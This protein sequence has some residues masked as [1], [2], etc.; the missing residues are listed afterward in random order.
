M[1]GISIF[2]LLLLFNVSTAVAYI[3]WVRP[4]SS[5]GA[6]DEVNALAI[7][8]EGNCY[9]TGNANGPYPAESD[10]RTIKYD[11]DGNVL[12]TAS[13]DGIAQEADAATA[14]ALSQNGNVYVTGNA[15]KAWYDDDIAI[16]KYSSDGEQIWA[17][18][19]TDYDTYNDFAK[20]LDT[21]DFGS[22]YVAGSI[23]N[24]AVLIKY[25]PNGSVE[26]TRL[27]DSGDTDSGE[28]VIVAPD[29]YIRLLVKHDDDFA[30][31]CYNQSGDSL[32]MTIHDFRT[33][34]DR[35]YD[36]DIDADGNVYAVGSVYN[37]VDTTLNDWGIIKVAPEG[38]ILWEN[39]YDGPAQ[40]LSWDTPYAV[41]TLPSGGAYVTGL[42][43]SSSGST[44]L[45]T[46]RYDE[47]GVRI[48]IDFYD[49][50]YGSTEGGN[51]VRFH[52][53]GGCVV[54]G[55]YSDATYQ[56]ALAIR[57]DE[58]G[59]HQWKELWRDGHTNLNALALDSSGDVIAAG[60]SSINYLTMK[61]RDDYEV[62]VEVLMK[63]GIYPIS[64]PAEEDSFRFTGVIRNN[65][66]SNQTIDLAVHLTLPNG[67]SHGPLNLYRNIQLDAYEYLSVDPV[68]QAVPQQAPAGTYIYYATIGEYPSQV[69]DNSSFRFTKSGSNRGYELTDWNIP[70][71]F[72]RSSIVSDTPGHTSLLQAYPN[73]FNATTT[74][75]YRL[76]EASFVKLDVFN[77]LGQEVTILED[78][79]KKA[80]HHT[81]SWDASTQSS[82]VYFYKLEVNG[83]VVTKRMTLVK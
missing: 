40:E 4:N 70:G 77:L 69:I 80:G 52:P 18:N 78:G 63:P 67:Q 42:A 41:S 3:D 26:W 43:R 59:N 53:D 44:D 51:D 64:L 49:S 10:F 31:A 61:F 82:G 36:M 32:W 13:Y 35:P 27:I 16:V 25:D 65:T 45:T 21:D 60:Y 50:P 81:V 71:W 37:V 11:L 20:D 34:I 17:R 24:D 29:G 23:G 75:N 5:Y 73:P 38:D 68:Y 15:K 19:F 46:I 48:W 66:G 28:K 72:D 76:P 14:I 8:S 57:Y 55:Y 62:D 12:W 39:V 22:V 54:V 74:I 79:Y 83:E 6:N 2:A 9:V 56:Y 47:S 30:V 33:D 7:D 58:D 1:R